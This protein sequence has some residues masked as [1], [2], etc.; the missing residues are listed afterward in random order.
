MSIAVPA[1]SAGIYGYPP[2]EATHIIVEAA[3]DFVNSEDTSVRSVRLVGYDTAMA[4]R[5]AAAISSFP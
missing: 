2:D 5:F 4:K 1:I 3:T